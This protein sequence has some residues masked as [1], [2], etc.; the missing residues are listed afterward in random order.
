MP[1]SMAEQPNAITYRIAVQDDEPEIFALLT[2]VAPEIPIPLD[3]PGTEGRKITDSRMT[4][5]IVQCRGGSWVAV[6]ASG[7]VVGFAL[8]RRD[9]HATD[10]ATS[11]KY[12]GVSGSSRGLGISSNLVN[13]LKAKGVPLTATVLSG[14]QSNMADRF[15]K[16]G[17]RKLALMTRKQDFGGTH[18]MPRKPSRPDGPEQTKRFIETAEEVGV[19]NEKALDR[20]FRKIAPDRHEYSHCVEI[21]GCSL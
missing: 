13:N 9:L 3:Q 2:E 20:A 5:E 7:N 11:L 16:F 21:V 8:A 14:N 19:T 15:V 1:E 12:I 10:R 4:T 6:D 17:S 18:K